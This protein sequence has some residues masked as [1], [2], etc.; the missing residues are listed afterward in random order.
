MP[1]NTQLSNALVNAQADLLAR[2]LDAGFL[3]I[4]DGAQPASADT[5]ITTQLMLA[6]LEL[7]DPS[8]AAAVD[9]V[10]TF[11][12]APAVAEAASA[13]AWYRLFKVDGST[14]VLDGSVGVTGSTANLQLS[15]VD[16]IV[17][18]IVA[19]TAFQHTVFKS[20]IGL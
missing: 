12:P 1:R 11:T 2:Q 8:A 7:P 4:Y 3:R 17:G 19:V 14:A 5:A 15:T 13:A 16:L 6:E 9:G 18:A 10:L 20:Q